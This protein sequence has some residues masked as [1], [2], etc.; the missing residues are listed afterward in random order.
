MGGEGPDK[1]KLVY[2]CWDCPG[3]IRISRRCA[4]EPTEE[5]VEY[6]DAVAEAKEKDLLTGATPGERYSQ[7]KELLPLASPLVARAMQ[8]LA[9]VENSYDLAEKADIREGY[10]PFGKDSTNPILCPL[11]RITQATDRWIASWRRASAMAVGMGGN[12][13]WCGKGAAYEDVRRLD[14]FSA[15]G[16]AM[17]SKS[18]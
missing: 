10:G 3:E 15:I 1:D 13:S 5:M 17:R 7:A 16:S 14:A 4:K 2:T 18:V 6:L 12:L 8:R 9:D 11:L